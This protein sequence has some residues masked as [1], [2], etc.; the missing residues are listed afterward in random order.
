[1]M[2]QFIRFVETNVDG[3]GTNAEVLVLFKTDSILTNGCK[4]RLQK[5]LSEL[6]QEWEPDEWDTDSAVM[7]ALVRTFGQAIVD[8]DVEVILP[9]I[10]VEF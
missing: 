6:K 9:D 2:N 3:C 7:E 5:A 10:E 8:E 4:E 1:M